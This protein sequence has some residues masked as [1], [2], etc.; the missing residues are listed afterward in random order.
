MRRRRIVV[1]VRAGPAWG[2]GP[3]EAQPEWDAHAK[4]VDELVERGEM[5]M[6]GPFADNSGSLV[7]LEGVDEDEVRRLLEA[8]PFVVNGVFVVDDVRDW[9]IYVDALTLQ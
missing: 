7:L 3:P 6:G 5:V 1:R 2:D 8:D 4:F 9:T